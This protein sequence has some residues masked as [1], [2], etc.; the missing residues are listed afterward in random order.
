M[1]RDRENHGN[2]KARCGNGWAKHI[3]SWEKY[4]YDQ[5]QHIIVIEW[6]TIMIHQMHNINQ[7]RDVYA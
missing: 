7:A 5:L 2:D 1:L 3:T 6:N 4:Y